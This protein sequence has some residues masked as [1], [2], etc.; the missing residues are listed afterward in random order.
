MFPS[1][2]SIA[3]AQ[4][5][6]LVAWRELVEQVQD[7]LFAHA[8]ALVGDVPRAERLA[9]A[10]LAEAHRRIAEVQDAERFPRW[11]LRVA[12]RLY[13]RSGA[14]SRLAAAARSHDDTAPRAASP[15]DSSDALPDALA[16]VR[17]L[18]KP[19]ERSVVLLVHLAGR[20]PA[21]VAPF[22][23]VLPS[24]VHSRL[25]V[26]HRRL[27]KST[28]RRLAHDLAP[29]RPSRDRRFVTGVLAELSAA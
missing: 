18:P 4:N 15:E 7:V 29:L 20:D 17:A 10:A 5:G 21:A 3:R 23:G 28:V 6:D 26:A 11:L 13:D 22:L 16:S 8:L 2:V 27:K 14:P 9:R 19:R 1:P 24:E 25:A 12:E